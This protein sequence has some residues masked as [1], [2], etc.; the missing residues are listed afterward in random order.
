MLR[1][2]SLI[3]LI[4][5]C[6]ALITAFPPDGWQMNN[7]YSYE[8]DLENEI[9]VFTMRWP[10]GASTSHTV[11]FSTHDCSGTAT[12]IANV[13]YIP[14]TSELLKLLYIQFLSVNNLPLP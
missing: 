12:A 10:T 7:V 3:V 6:T 2:S 4:L 9:M 5:S 1:L 13:N 8:G 14:T 11:K